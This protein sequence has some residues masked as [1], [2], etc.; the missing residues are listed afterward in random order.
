MPSTVRYRST[1]TD[2]HAARL[3]R[4]DH[5]GQGARHV[6]LPFRGVIE[7]VEADLV[8]QPPAPQQLGF[9]QRGAQGLQTGVQ[10]HCKTS[11]KGSRKEVAVKVTELALMWGGRNCGR[12]SNSP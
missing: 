10:T 2:P 5:A 8:A 4:P 12:M 11:N 6:G 1:T 7:N 3:D 9:E